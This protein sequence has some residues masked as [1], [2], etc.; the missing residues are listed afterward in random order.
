MQ[1]LPTIAVSLPLP[2]VYGLKA[3]PLWS[4]PPCSAVCNYPASMFV[5]TPPSWSAVCNNQPS[6]STVYNS[7]AALL[8]CC[9]SYQRAYS[10]CSM[11]LCVCLFFIALLPQSDPSLE[12]LWSRTGRDKHTLYPLKSCWSLAHGV[13]LVSSGKTF[14]RRFVH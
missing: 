7:Y 8:G 5:I 12:L 9:L 2:Y 6:C 11:C 3:A 1:K 4:Q 14:R 13:T 10:N